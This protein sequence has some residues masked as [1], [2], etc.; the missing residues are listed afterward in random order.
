MGYTA[1]EGRAVGGISLLCIGFSLFLER[2]RITR[3]VDLAI[4]VVPK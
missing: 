4:H 2:M 1:K 3:Y